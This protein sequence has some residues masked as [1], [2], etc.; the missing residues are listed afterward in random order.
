MALKRGHEMY[1]L[2]RHVSFAMIV[3]VSMTSHAAGIALAS[4]PL[5]QQP[6]DFI[7]TDLAVQFSAEPTDGI[8]SGQTIHFTVSVTNHGP[9]PV[10]SVTLMSSNF[11]DEFYLDNATADCQA[12]LTRITDGNGF[13]YYNQIWYPAFFSTLEVGEARTCHF[14]LDFSHLAPPVFPFSFGLASYETDLNP[15]NDTQAV[16]LR[17]GRL[18]ATLPT[19]SPQAQILLGL[20]MLACAGLAIRHRRRSFSTQA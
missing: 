1:A 7:P 18:P 19:L 2:A 11:V 13:Y 17:R 4:K 6:A 8:E 9:E 12:F 14:T 20:G 15:A 16:V 3:L 10:E 5:P